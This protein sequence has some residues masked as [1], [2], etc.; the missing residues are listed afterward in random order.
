MKEKGKLLKW[1]LILLITSI[2][3]ALDAKYLVGS[4]WGLNYIF[5]IFLSIWLGVKGAAYWTAAIGSACILIDAFIPADFLDN[6]VVFAE[7]SVS[8]IV[9]WLLAYLTERRFHSNIKFSKRINRF[10]I[11][12]TLSFLSLIVIFALFYQQQGEKL[13]TSFLDRQQASLKIATNEKKKMLLNLFT[14]LSFIQEFENVKQVHTKK[15]A[16]QHDLVAFMRMRHQYD[17]IRVLDTNGQE[18]V[19]VNQGN[20]VTVVPQE[21][22]QNKADRDYFKNAKE[23]SGNQFYLSEISLNKEHGNVSTPMKPVIRIV[24]PIISEHQKQGILVINFLPFIAK[25]AVSSSEHAFPVQI[26]DHRG[27]W[28]EGVPEKFLF[29]HKEGFLSDS[30]ESTTPRFWEQLSGK[31]TGQFYTNGDCIIFEKIQWEDLFIG[32]SKKRLNSSILTSENSFVALKRIPAEVL[33]TIEHKDAFVFGLFFSLLLL[34]LF[35]VEVYIFEECLALDNKTLKNTSLE[36]EILESNELFKDL[37]EVTKLGVWR[38][39]LDEM[40][41]EWD[42]M[43]YQ[44]HEVP[45]QTP[46]NIEE[47]IHFYR[48]DYQAFMK[49]VIDEATEKRKSWDVQAVLVTAKK[50]EIWVRAMGYPIIKNGQLKEFRGMFMNIDDIKRN[51]TL[52]AENKIRFQLAVDAARLGIWDWDI[53]NSTLIWDESI[54][55]IFGID[56][57]DYSGTCDAWQKTLFKEDAFAMTMAIDKALAGEEPFDTVFKVISKD[58][59]LKHIMAKGNVTFDTTGKAKRM[60]G[61]IKNITYQVEAEAEIVALNQNLETQVK[62]RTHEL[63]SVTLELEQQ[64]SLLNTSLILSTTDASGI[65]SEVN[66]TLCTIS[67]YSREELIGQNQRLLLSPKSLN[68]YQ[69]IF[70]EIEKGHFWKGEVCNLSKGGDEYWV[71]L[72]I[73]PFYDTN[74]KLTKLLS[75]SYDITT[76]KNIQAGMS[77]QSKSLA[78]TNGKLD[79]ANKELEAFSYSVSH[80]LKA[81]LRAIQGFSSNLSKKYADQLDETGVRWLAFIQDNATQMDRLIND[82]LAFAQIGKKQMTKTRT[83]MR[84]MIET[85]IE[86]FKRIY[87]AETNITIHEILSVHCDPQM[88]EMVWQNL[89]ENAFKY[90]GKKSEI[91]IEIKSEQ[92]GNFV[93]YSISDQGAGF[94]MRYYDK[95]FGVF[96]RLHSTEE[97]EGSGVGLASSQRIIQ[98]HGGDISAHSILGEGTTFE[99]KL[100]NHVNYER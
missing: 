31:T 22:L 70:K 36:K 39:L 97:F 88:M 52:L 41:V 75:I 51:E 45:N 54:Y 10:F 59:S 96:Q 76:L 78:K 63:K 29:G 100:P 72:S 34:I 28:F 16:L 49:Q 48:E 95:L 38:I 15:E 44:I 3:F 18:I 79:A 21:Q 4:S 99:F 93:N 55:E 60:T 89:I 91:N 68:S 56:A 1:G 81:P 30:I 40:R 80:D 92:V 47:A 77:N 84:E 98:K 53:V 65:I 66:D 37:Q 27:Y 9:L 67:G 58:G 23:L 87:P 5:L 94:D 73:K 24:T 61:V 85:K 35:F 82:M 74:G 12:S 46:I 33:F 26:L 64:L 11:L 13:K 43:T 2:L 90:S 20:P 86:H 32:T 7:K 69:K 62:E 83:E 19:R 8:I 14:D 6:S 57:A 50:R 17:Q 42:E 71:D 25:N